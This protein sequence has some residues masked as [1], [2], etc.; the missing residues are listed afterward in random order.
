MRSFSIIFLTLI[1]IFSGGCSLV[2]TKSFFFSGP[3]DPL[4]QALMALWIWGVV[5]CVACCALIYLISRTSAPMPHLK[6]R[7]S[8]LPEDFERQKKDQG[9]GDDERLR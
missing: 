7:N 3:S 5:I 1:A 4:G 2:F 8:S 6:D 9:P